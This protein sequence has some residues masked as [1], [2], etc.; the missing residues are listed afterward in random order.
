MKDR[1]SRFRFIIFALIVFL[2]GYY[3]G[4]SKIAL[5]WN[6]YKP[7]LSV[8]SKEP[9]PGLVNV[10]FSPFWIV[11]QRL[12][13]DYYDKSKLDQHKMLDGAIEGL[14]QSVGDPFTLYLPPTQ[15][16]NFK[17]N[18]QGQFSGIGAELGLKDK[19]IIVIAPLDGSPA[20]KAGIKAGDQ[21]FAVDGKSV[22]S[23]SLSQAVDKIRGP[24]G[25]SVTLTVLHKDSQS[26]QD[27]KIVRDTITVKS[28]DGWVKSVKDIEGIKLDG[29][30]NDNKDKGIAYI[31]LSQFGDNT[32]NDWIALINKLNLQIQQN[33]NVKGI[34]LDLRNNPGGYLTDAVFVAG[35][36]LPEG[37]PVVGEDNGLDKKTLYVSRRGL[38]MDIPLVVL[39]NRG[40][41]SASEIV[42][43]ALRDNK[44]AI[45]IGEKSFGKGTIQQAEDLG[46]GAGLHVTIAKWLTPNGTWVNEKGLDPD[47][48]VGLD[49]NDPSHDSQLEKAIGE[50]VK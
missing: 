27:I 47:V 8:V 19:Q 26:P 50:L 6:N 37:A 39:I 21:L 3:V 24:R 18:L 5:D 11:W 15:N 36:F 9:P 31:R 13:N 48:S 29:V 43:G 49:S 32:N 33:K 4:V 22:G 25:T 38:F 30:L 42:S 28:V 46:D 45:L 14:V 35:E 41:A 1:L 10:D 34:I 40:S 12:Q 23:W 2:I 17:Q 16:T 7:T 20:Q 44:R